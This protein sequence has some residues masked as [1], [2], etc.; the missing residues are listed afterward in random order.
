MEEAAMTALDFTAA[1][2]G[3]TAR[4]VARLMRGVAGVYRAYKNRRAFYRLGELS[5]AELADIGLSRSDL[6]V[7]FSVPL[8]VDPTVRLRV[9][10]DERIGAI[11][12]CA[13]R[14]S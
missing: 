7:A 2:T 11:E 3:R 1:P 10:A 6:H 9:L 5:D 12:D 14:V 13:R 4:T 8:G